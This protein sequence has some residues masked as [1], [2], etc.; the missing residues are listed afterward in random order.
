MIDTS[1]GM[2]NIFPQLL[3]EANH[4][5]QST[6]SDGCDDHS[7][8]GLFFC[9]IRA[10]LATKHSL[11]ARGGAGRFLRSEE[12]VMNSGKY[13]DVRRCSRRDISGLWLRLRA[14]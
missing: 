7:L 9:P 6:A 3:T 14:E 4:V 12:D 2:T 10:V 13:E 11:S 5:D 8:S 1:Q